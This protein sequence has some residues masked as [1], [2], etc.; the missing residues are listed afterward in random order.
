MTR[1]YREQTTRRRGISVNVNDGD[2][3]RALR[4]FKRKVEDA[5]LLKDLQERQCYDKPSVAKKKARSAAKKRWQ[6]KLQNESLPR[7]MY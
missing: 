1:N 6:R 3:T 7:R 5:G 4:K 2:V